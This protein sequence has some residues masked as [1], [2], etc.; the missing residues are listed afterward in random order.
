[1]KTETLE[2]TKTELDYLLT[3]V[4]EHINSGIYWGNQEQFNEMEDGVLEKIEQA[5][6]SAF[7]HKVKS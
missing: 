3:L 1:M 2:L 4:R 7:N 5:Y 6:N